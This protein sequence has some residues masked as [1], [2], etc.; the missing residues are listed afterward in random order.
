VP[1]K[2]PRSD[3]PTD[4]TDPSQPPGRRLNA[5]EIAELD[6]LLV[7]HGLY[8]Y[9]HTNDAG[10]LNP[11]FRMH[12]VLLESGCV[13]YAFDVGPAKDRRL[14]LDQDFI[15]ARATDRLLEAAR[16]GQLGFWSQAFVER[17]VWNAAQPLKREEKK[18]RELLEL[19]ATKRTY[20]HGAGQ[21]ATPGSP[22]GANPSAVD[23]FYPG[24]AGEPDFR[25]DLARFR[26]ELASERLQTIHD[27]LVIDYLDRDR[28]ESN[29][30]D[31]P[32]EGF[33]LRLFA[34]ATDLATLPVQPRSV[35]VAN[36]SGEL[37]FRVVNARGDKVID[38]SEKAFPKK[39]EAIKVLRKDLSDMWTRDPRKTGKQSWVIVKVTEITRP[40][41]PEP[42]T[43]LAKKITK[44]CDTLN[45][46]SLGGLRVFREENRFKK[47]EIWEYALRLRQEFSP[48][49]LSDAERNKARQYGEELEANK[50]AY[51]V[52]RLIKEHN[53]RLE[54]MHF[55]SLLQ[56]ERPEITVNAVQDAIKGLCERLGIP[57]PLRE[58]PRK[59][60]R[61]AR[62]ALE[63][64]SIL[65]NARI[66]I[67]SLCEG[68]DPDE[69][70][71]AVSGGEG[72][73]ASKLGLIAVAVTTGY[74]GIVRQIKEINALSRFCD[75]MGT[76][77]SL[78][79]EVKGSQ[80]WL[81]TRTR[82]DQT[83][84]IEAVVNRIEKTRRARFEWFLDNFEAP[85][86][87]AWPRVLEVLGELQFA[88]RQLDR[89]RRFYSEELC[90]K[91]D[92][93]ENLS[94]LI[95]NTAHW[96]TVP[97]P[98]TTPDVD[99]V[100]LDCEIDRVK[101]SKLSELLECA[102]RRVSYS[103]L[104]TQLELDQKPLFALLDEV[105]RV[106]LKHHPRELRRGARKTRG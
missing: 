45:R 5:V 41:D 31:R 88:H 2:T 56:K 36:V 62:A 57:D 98:E 77:G 82:R 3:L 13:R 99:G 78:R 40:T 94:E 54:N 102:T 23:Y 32:Y 12:Q 69:L 85:V 59:V 79:H 97:G 65:K 47:T 37:H 49:W 72:W 101:Y 7:R 96:N 44:I 91:I 63:T 52:I 90:K 92:V 68:R 8:E 100:R 38:A 93:R 24:R 64:F 74:C 9:H 46:S 83:Q 67:Q 34:S 105:R 29:E 18:Q 42:F 4:A 51:A 30:V 11:I 19:A 70:K 95:A 43:G 86:P 61:K 60:D 39:V 75:A 87:L 33:D 58:S 80:S 1:R 21:R 16:L 48:P 103:E 76:R 28:S 66:L 17:A 27:L 53:L 71:A 89:V 20:A 50:D 35:V 22:G 81:I 26:S 6:L 73:S 25:N 55:K 14:H 10:V 15:V 106:Y 104:G 84:E